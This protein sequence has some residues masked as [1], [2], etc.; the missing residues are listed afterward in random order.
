MDSIL[1]VAIFILMIAL[2]F[3][4]KAFIF[5]YEIK[6][7]PNNLNNDELLKLE[8]SLSEALRYCGFWIGFTVF[9]LT[10]Y[11]IYLLLK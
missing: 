7:N 11:G 10:V 4:F 9:Y 2:F 6:K 8:G 5:S 3:N 1:Q